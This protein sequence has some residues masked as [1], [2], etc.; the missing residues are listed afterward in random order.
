[1]EVSLILTVALAAAFIVVVLALVAVIVFQ[2]W[3]ISDNNAHLKEFIDE[4][5]EMRD[6][7]RRY[8][9]Q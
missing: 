5:L 3:R 8:K 9:E 4:N 2:R 7:L 6:K 1:M